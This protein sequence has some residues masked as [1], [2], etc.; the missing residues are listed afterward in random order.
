[1]PCWHGRNGK[2][3]SVTCKIC[4][5]WGFHLHLMPPLCTNVVS[6][7]S[8]NPCFTARSISSIMLSKIWASWYFTGLKEHTEVT[9]NKKFLTIIISTARNHRAH[10]LF[11]LRAF[12]IFVFFF[13]H[14]FNQLF[15]Q[16]TEQ[17]E[18]VIYVSKN[19]FFSVPST[20]MVMLC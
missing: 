2:T 12:S 19:S 9:I 10:D 8:P 20:E 16:Y 14:L 4:Q 6:K 1:M 7:Q 15:F 18:L 11:L 13:F 3:W 17:A 5:Q